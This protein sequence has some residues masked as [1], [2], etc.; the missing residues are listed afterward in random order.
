M[1]EIVL[2]RHG[3]T[4]WSAN[5]RHTSRTDLPLTRVGERQAQALRWG[6]ANRRFGL[7]LC[8][9]RRRARDTASLAGLDLATV[10]DDL[11]EWDYGEYEGLTSRQI[12]DAAGN[13]DW[14]L[15]RDGCPG[16]ESPGQVGE[17]VD[18][19]LARATKALDEGDVA[20][21]GHGHCLR[22][23]G[24][25]WVGLPPSAGALFDLDTG[26]LCVLGHEHGR[27]VLQSWNARVERPDSD[28]DPASY[29]DAGVS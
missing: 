20:L 2:V 3:Q 11:A 27:R 1:A 17:R 22:V 15:W 6:L 12:H 5:G 24:A 19:V 26:T 8:S 29:V 10:D 23:A 16:G 21:V 4:E 28:Q 13:D 14:S 18:R 7:I 25:R 9:P